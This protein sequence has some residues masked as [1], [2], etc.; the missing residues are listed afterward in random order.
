MRSSGRHEPRRPTPR[1]PGRVVCYSC[2]NSY[3]RLPV[4]LEAPSTRVRRGKASLRWARDHTV[5]GEQYRL[6]GRFVARFKGSRVSGRLSLDLGPCTT[7][8]GDDS[9]VPFQARRR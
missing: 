8:L 9:F 4:V 2:P 1:R 7:R 5:D 6:T 3:S